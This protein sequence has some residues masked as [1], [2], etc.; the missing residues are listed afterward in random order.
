M[1]FIDIALYVSYG[2]LGFST[3]AIV[4]LPVL[5]L[6]NQPGALVGPL[7]R[8]GA[9]VVVFV[10]LRALSSNS[11]GD[12]TVGMFKSVGAGLLMMYILVILSLAGIFFSEMV[13]IF[14][15]S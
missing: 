6:L 7:V 8:L 14:K 4:V 15:K 13:G 9:L 11:I 12:Q 10:I 3:L 2:V 1:D 5:R